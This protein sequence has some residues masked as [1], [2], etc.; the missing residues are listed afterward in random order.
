MARLTISSATKV[1]VQ[2][3]A[4][5]GANQGTGKTQP[6]QNALNGA[7]QRASANLSISAADM[8][9]SADDVNPV[10]SGV[11]PVS[12]I[13]STTPDTTPGAVE[14]H[15]PILSEL[16]L[17]TNHDESAPPTHD[18]SESFDDSAVS[19]DRRRDSLSARKRALH[20]AL[21]PR[22][23]QRYSDVHRHERKARERP[24]ASLKTQYKYS[25]NTGTRLRL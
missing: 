2:N 9:E 14:G 8:G 5:N 20:R 16:F 23:R 4:S 12:G 10:F 6:H 21:P 13:P 11:W 7:D 3:R 25:R 18:H 24:T 19:G 22:F 15:S 1:F 17:T